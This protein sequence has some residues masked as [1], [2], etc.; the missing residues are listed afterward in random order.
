MDRWFA[1]RHGRTKAQVARCDNR[2][3]GGQP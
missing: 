1:D 2:R 3:G